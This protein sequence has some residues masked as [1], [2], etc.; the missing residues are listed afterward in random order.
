MTSTGCQASPPR[1]YSSVGGNG[2]KILS[3]PGV[4]SFFSQADAV[5]IDSAILSVVVG[6]L[7]GYVSGLY[8]CGVSF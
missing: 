2:R 8:S 6:R 3:N 7:R 1:L 5:T 4:A